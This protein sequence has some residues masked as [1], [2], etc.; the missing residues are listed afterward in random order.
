MTCRCGHTGTGPHPC[1]GRL[2]TCRQPAT[3]RYVGTSACLAGAQPKS[4]AYRT[5][6]CDECWR[7]FRADSAP[8]EPISQCTA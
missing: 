4:G 5:W 2:Y 3:S 7:A 6:A 1:H 8:S